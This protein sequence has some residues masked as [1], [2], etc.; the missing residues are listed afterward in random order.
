MKATSASD[1]LGQSL[2]VNALFKNSA[3]VVF[4]LHGRQTPQTPGEAIPAWLIWRPSRLH[5]WEPAVR[6]QF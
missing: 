4:M 6:S 5:G 1:P 2:S 3:L